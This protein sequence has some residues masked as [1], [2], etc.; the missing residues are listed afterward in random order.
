M[1]EFFKTD[2]PRL[3]NRGLLRLFATT[4]LLVLP[5]RALEAQQPDGKPI[6]RIDIEGNRRVESAGLRACIISRPGDAYSAETVRRDVQAL[7]DTGFFEDVRVEVEDSPDQP[8]SKIVVFI[9][10]EKP[11]VTRIEYKGNT[12][13]TR[14]EILNAL[15]DKKVGLSVGDWFDQTKLTRA[16]LVIK[17]LLSVR[18]SPSATVKPTFERFAS[19]NTVNVVFNIDEGPKSQPSSNPR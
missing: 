18:G 4:C 6:E 10:R 14:T 15:K 9:V 11:I 7:H 16:A 17:G 1:E 3:A 2:A 12:S 19:S 13:I 5:A 8:N